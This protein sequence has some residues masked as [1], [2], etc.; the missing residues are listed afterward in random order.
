MVWVVIVWPGEYMDDGPEGL[1]AFETQADAVAWILVNTF[2]SHD[3]FEV[4]LNSEII[5][6]YCDS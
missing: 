2:G 4:P 6:K 1:L 5:T 3:L